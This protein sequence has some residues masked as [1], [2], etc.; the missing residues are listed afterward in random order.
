MLEAMVQD[1]T[2]GQNYPLE[3]A[4]LTLKKGAPSACT[5]ALQ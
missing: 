2:L 1:T 3:L 5:N 4:L